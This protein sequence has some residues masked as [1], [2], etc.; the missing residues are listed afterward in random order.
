MSKPLY[1]AQADPVA[2]V[3]AFIT[4]YA[5]DDNFRPLARMLR[6]FARQ[7]VDVSTVVPAAFVIGN[8]TLAKATTTSATVN[9]TALPAG[10][11]DVITKLQYK[12]NAGSWVDLP[13]ATLIGSRTI[14]GLTSASTPSV[15]LRAVNSL[16]VAAAGDTKSVSLA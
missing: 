1:V 14:T 2:D 10:R 3:E 4:K 6:R 5:I 8:W 12:V 7:L 15:Q 11:G 16:G 13:G 9:V